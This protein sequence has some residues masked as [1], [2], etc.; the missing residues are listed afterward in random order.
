MASA[1][2]RQ[3]AGHAFT[4]EFGRLSDSH[5]VLYNAW[6]SSLAGHGTNT[7]SSNGV[8]ETPTTRAWA[9]FDSAAAERTA[10]IHRSIS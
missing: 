5:D 6:E 8:L 3:L 9:V 4:A 1:H 7:P 10:I 2:A